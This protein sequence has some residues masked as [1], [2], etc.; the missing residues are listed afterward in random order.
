MIGTLTS[1]LIESTLPDPSH[2]VVFDLDLDSDVGAD[3]CM[4]DA[5]TIITVQTLI[6]RYPNT[7][8]MTAL[9]HASNLRFM[10]VNCHHTPRSRVECSQDSSSCDASSLFDGGQVFALSTLRQLLY[11]SFTKNSVLSLVR[12]IL[13]LDSSEGSGH[14]NYVVVDEITLQRCSEFGQLYQELCLTA[15]EIPIAI[16]RTELVNNNKSL[17]QDHVTTVGTR[18]YVI[19][20]PVEHLKLLTGDI[21]YVLQ[22]P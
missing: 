20:N 7:C 13:N 14:L 12:L 6:R 19:T 3:D 5:N 22:P 2:L 16:Y 10:H 21:I 17:N 15:G 8:V 18:S 1:A 11:K 9:N 4:T